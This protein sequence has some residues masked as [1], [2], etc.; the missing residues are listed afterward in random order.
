MPIPPVPPFVPVPVAPT[1]EAPPPPPPPNADVVPALEPPLLPCDGL[2]L[3]VLPAPPASKPFLTEPPPPEP[4]A[5]PADVLD[6]APPL[7]PPVAVMVE[8]TES[9]PFAL[10]APPAPTVTVYAVA[11]ENEKLV[12]S[13]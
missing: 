11:V 10:A 5:V 12:P 2:V 9:L 8:N 7:P 1:A 6:A 3:G 13:L 4:P